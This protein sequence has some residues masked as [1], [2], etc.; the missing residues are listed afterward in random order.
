MLVLFSKYSQD[1]SLPNCATGILGQSSSFPG[2]DW[3]KGV[4]TVFPVDWPAS[5]FYPLGTECDIIQ[6]TSRPRRWWAYA[7]KNHHVWVRI[8]SPF[9]LKGVY[10]K[11]VRKVRHFWVPI[12]LQ[13][14]RLISSAYRHSQVGLIRRIL[15]AKQRCFSLMLTTW[16]ARVPKMATV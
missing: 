5:L 6:K 15:G 7:S 14:N 3:V 12:S 11:G 9:I 8:Q 13:E 16:E 4:L 10:T 2:L 1:W